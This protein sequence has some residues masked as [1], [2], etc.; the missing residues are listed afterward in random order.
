MTTTEIYKQGLND[1]LNSSS[2]NVSDLRKIALKA[3]T[4]RIKEIKDCKPLNWMQ[5][6]DQ[7]FEWYLDVNGVTVACLVNE[8]MDNKNWVLADYDTDFAP[9]FGDGSMPKFDSLEAGKYYAESKFLLWLKDVSE[10]LLKPQANQI[11]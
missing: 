7:N 9:I 11:P 4:K 5:F 6:E 2:E 3:F 10:L 1:I 8:E